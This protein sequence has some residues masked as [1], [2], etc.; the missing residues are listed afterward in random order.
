[1]LWTRYFTEAQGYKL[2][3]SVLNQDNMSVMLLETNGKESSSKRT[4]HINVQHFF[5]KDRVASSEITIKNC[6][7][8]D[9]LADSFTKSV[10]G[11]QFRRL[12]SQI[13]GIPE[14]R[15]DALLGWDR[16][17]LKTKTSF[18]LDSPIPQE[19]VGTKPKRT[20][21]T[22]SALVSIKYTIPS[23]NALASGSILASHC[24]NRRRTSR[25]LSS[26]DDVARRALKLPT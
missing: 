25:R 24:A 22:A 18:K 15:N 3:E 10:Q 17:S 20:N 5:I 9:M 7:T 23:A 12:R 26:Y 16:P 1:M 2:S 19:C 4:K 14:D 13:Q 8:D 6:S 11:N 21:G